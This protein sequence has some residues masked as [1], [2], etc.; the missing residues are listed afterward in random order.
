[1]SDEIIWKYLQVGKCISKCQ[2]SRH[3]S[4]FVFPLLHFW[5]IKLFGSLLKTCTICLWRI[6]N[7]RSYLYSSRYP[8]LEKPRQKRAVIQDMVK[9]LK[10]W[11]LRHR[12]NPY[13]SKAEK[14]QLALGSNM[15]LIQV[16]QI[17]CRCCIFIAYSPMQ[18]HIICGLLIADMQLLQVSNWFA[19]AR[20]RLKNV[21]QEPRC[22][23]S[24]RLRLYNQFVQGNAEL[25][26]ISSDDSIWNSE[27]EEGTLP[28]VVLQLSLFTCISAV[29]CP[30]HG[31]N[32][33]PSP[34]T[35]Q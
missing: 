26:S 18:R 30:W 16:L 25:L 28:T 11:L 35:Q 27:D 21:V 24:K 14:V 15:T 7:V 23:W 6:K 20:R 33:T 5:C 29:F 2:D 12:H 9:P 10:I 1:M 19:N 31:V 34:P 13:P 8:V 17:I 32:L 3:K 22:S 4:V